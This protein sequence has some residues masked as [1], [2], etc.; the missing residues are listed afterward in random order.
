VERPEPRTLAIAAAIVLPLAG[1]GWHLR[2]ERLHIEDRAS[3]AASAVAG[4]PV[5]VH[6]PGQLRRR[7]LAEIND[8]EVQFTDG[9][10]ADETRLTARVCDGLGRLLDQGATLDLRCLQLDAC[11]ADDTSVAYGVA[12]LTHESVHMRG[13]MDEAVT[14]CQ[15]VRRAASVARALGAS[16]EAAAFIADWQFSVAD[17]RL[18]ERYQTSADCRAPGAAP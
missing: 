10:P 11:S 14:E 17:D 2:A 15:A 8:G 3:A 13:V 12:V 16:A 9:V 5:R 18:P 1:L 7:F 4:R 6:C